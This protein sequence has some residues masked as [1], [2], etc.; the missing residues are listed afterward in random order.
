MVDLPQPSCRLRRG[1]LGY[2]IALG[3]YVSFLAP[4]SNCHLGV[5]LPTCV[6]MTRCLHGYWHSP[7]SAHAPGAGWA[8]YFL[9]Q[10]AVLP[11]AP[12]TELEGAPS[13]CSYRRSALL[14]VGGFPE[15]LR[16]GEDTVVNHALVRR[17]Y[18]AY[19]AQ[20]VIFIHHSPC[21]TPW[22]LVAHLRPVGRGFGSILRD[23]DRMC[24]QRHSSTSCS[25]NLVHRRVPAV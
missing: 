12:S 14:A 5:S 1:T 23:R 16:R 24:P 21:R 18:Q 8:S 22:K 13:H 15:D 20:D 10:S 25:V 7:E 3:E 17:G 19:R 11:D 2:G 6:P 9:D 4:T